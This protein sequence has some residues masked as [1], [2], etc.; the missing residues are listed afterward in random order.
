MKS[1]EK[2]IALTFIVADDEAIRGLK[3]AEDETSLETEIEDA[4]RKRKPPKRYIDSDEDSEDKQN[5]LISLKKKGPCKRKVRRLSESDESGSEIL[6]QVS[7]SVLNAVK[8]NVYVHQDKE[9]ERQY[10]KDNSSKKISN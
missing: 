10:S 7:S 1:I 3:R 2:I 9:R 8:E 6:P 4:P 5:N